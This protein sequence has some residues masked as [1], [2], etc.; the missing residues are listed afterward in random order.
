M[1]G[2]GTRTFQR[3]PAVPGELVPPGTTWRANAAPGGKRLARR[4]KQLTTPMKTTFFASLLLTTACTTEATIDASVPID[5]VARG[6]VYGEELQGRYLLGNLADP[7]AGGG[8]FLSVANTSTLPAT[9]AL[10]TVKVSG[11]SLVATD[12]A[13]TS[14]SDPNDFVSMVFAGANGSELRVAA[15]DLSITTSPRYVLEYRPNSLAAWSDYCDP[16]L[17]TGAVPFQGSW[18]RDRRH[19]NGASLSFGCAGSGVTVK[20]VEWGYI[21]GVIGPGET[22]WDHHQAC[23]QMA[24]ANICMDGSTHTRELTPIWI[25]D[26][27]PG[28]Q[29]APTDLP[30]LERLDPLAT[31]PP[32]DKYYFEA[33]WQPDGP[34]IC[35]SKL[36]WASLPLGGYCP[37]VLPDPRVVEGDPSVRFCED[38]T[39]AE[40]QAAG[41]LLVN[42]SLPMDLPLHRWSN[43]AGDRV[44]SV[45]G[46]VTAVA[47]SYPFA[48]YTT[49]RGSDAILLR[50]LPGSLDPQTDVIE[51]FD[52]YDAA[53]G[54]RVV[55]PL[56]AGKPITPGHVVG[57]R[58]GYLLTA[59]GPDRVPFRLFRNGSDFTSTST[60]PAP[61][62]TFVAL[63]GYAIAP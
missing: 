22:N 57:A 47:E 40:L 7:L 19:L 14:Y 24:N 6:P 53:T 35:L 3:E 12:A 5:E 30:L 55:A 60:N 43:A 11:T 15:I 39:W 45:N 10:V 28:A 48:G 25:R 38:Y 16:A 37:A 61:G 51:V 29:P 46:Y 58:E 1:R 62:F 32:P 50:N 26:S 27:I 36:R 9:G 49:L 20:C 42:G 54:D 18:D 17:G 44:T 13:G 63:L 4:V 8:S 33:G 23:T 59:A 31:W 21:P 56:I 52:Q 41:A 2:T 34:A